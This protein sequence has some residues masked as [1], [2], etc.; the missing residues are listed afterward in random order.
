MK[1][2]YSSSVTLKNRHIV[3]VGCSR[4]I[5][6][7]ISQRLLEAGCHVSG[8]FRTSSSEIKQLKTQFESSLDT[9]CYDLRKPETAH[10]LVNEIKKKQRPVFA[11]I[12][13]ASQFF[14]TPLN[15]VTT[16][17]WD[18]LFDTNVKG[19]FF[20]TQAFIP[21]LD[22]PSHIINLVDIFATKPL[23]GYLAYTA[24]KGALLTLTKNL[25][26]ELAPHTQVNA[27]SP[28]PVLLPENFTEEEKRIHASRTLL[29]RTGSPED[30]WNAIYFL[31]NN[32][33]ITGQNLRIDG[34][35]SLVG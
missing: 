9:F 11:L 12:H 17:S 35:S 15:Q 26:N 16:D 10:N 27:V 23:R 4:R 3:V 30:I 21:H 25:A 29:G 33:Y 24:A 5:G 28:G 22:K 2:L 14:R 20:L 7:L 34:G 1:P 31:L 6:L 32:R 19:H 13:V 8:L 18:E